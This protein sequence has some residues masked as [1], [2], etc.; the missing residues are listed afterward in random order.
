MEE[1]RIRIRDREE[2]LHKNPLDIIKNYRRNKLLK[3]KENLIETKEVCSFC[4]EFCKMN[5]HATINANA[6]ANTT[7][8][9]NVTTTS[10][11]GF[12]LTNNAN[13][14]AI[15]KSS[16]KNYTVPS[17][18]ET[19]EQRLNISNLFTEEMKIKTSTQRGHVNNLFAEEIKIRTARAMN[20]NN[21]L[22]I[23]L[24][25][26]FFDST[27][28]NIGHVTTNVK[29][30]TVSSKT[31]DKKETTV[32]IMKEMEIGTTEQP[33][34]IFHTKNVSGKKPE[35]STL[36]N[37][38]KSGF[39]SANILKTIEMSN[40]APATKT[41]LKHK[42][43]ILTNFILSARANENI[44][45]KRRNK[46]TENVDL[47]NVNTGDELEYLFGNEHKPRNELYE[48]KVRAD[49]PNQKYSLLQ[50]LFFDVKKDVP[51]SVKENTPKPTA[52]KEN[53][54]RSILVTLPT[55]ICKYCKNITSNILVI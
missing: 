40:Y 55:I 33:V 25:S 44:N 42:K 47:M 15:T 7:F 50:P 8:K 27:I 48:D 5:T 32:E 30:Q 4:N 28:T 23:N 38:N 11:I 12:N 1:N 54:R 22:H 21:E 9:A 13:T 46:F 52:E 3:N 39:K 37:D 51:I 16:P 18:N 43:D 20:K 36:T 45:R 2:K 17:L 41:G 24:T 31:S 49:A 53:Y 29:E 34:K 6:T 26:T 10:F 14:S 19:S 35:V